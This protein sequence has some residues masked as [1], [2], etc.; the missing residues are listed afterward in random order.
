MP[1]N[2]H[3]PRDSYLIET[4]DLLLERYAKEEGAGYIEEADEEAGPA[5]PAVSGSRDA[6]LLLR[7]DFPVVD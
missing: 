5:D 6:E 7:G 3:T 2:P 4:I 1:A